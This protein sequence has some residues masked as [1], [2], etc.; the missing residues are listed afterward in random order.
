MTPA[1]VQIAHGMGEHA[2]RYREPLEPLMRAGWVIYANDHRGH[3]RGIRS[4]KTFRLEDC[5][6]DAAATLDLLG[7]LARMTR[8]SE[9]CCA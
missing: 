7:F 9:S 8:W 1:I 5:A 6:D 4:R 3:G 2:G